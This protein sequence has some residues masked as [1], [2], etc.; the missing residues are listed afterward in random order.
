MNKKY[1]Y[2]FVF[3]LAVSLVSAG[4]VN[5]LSNT[6][7]V[8]VSVM[9]PLT[10]TTD[11]INPVSVFGGEVV[12]INAE[13]TNNI[14][15]DVYGIYTTTVSNNLN[16]AGCD[17]FDSIGVII[18]NG[19]DAGTYTLLELDGDCSDDDG[20]AIISI[21]VMYTQNEV[22]SYTG[23]LEFKQNVE[24]ANYNMSSVILITT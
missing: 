5:Y 9:S 24:P 20:A 4:L 23:L 18:I 8:E 7:E 1:M 12:E 19:N 6:T 16:N 10:L 2:G 17:D 21:P 3:L 22:Q 11:I 15:E 14:A 13:V